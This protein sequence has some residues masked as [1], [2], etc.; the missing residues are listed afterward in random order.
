M[1]E[2]EP[3]TP[4]GFNM[5]IPEE[6]SEY[7]TQFAFSRDVAQNI[8]RQADWTCE[9]TGKK[10]A[11]GWRLEAAHDCHNKHY[12]YY[13]NEVN[14]KC[15]CIA[16][17]LKQHIK[18]LETCPAHMKGW[19]KASI[20]LIA[21]RAFTEGLRYSKHYFEYP[22]DIIDDRDEVVNILV[23]GGLDPEEYIF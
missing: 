3:V 6:Q 15:L 1:F 4:S 13:N 20:K 11:D 17:H 10:A 7:V 5:P 2:L 22:L 12:P 16:S 21:K 9:E 14:G 18:I 23:D 19:A 8:K